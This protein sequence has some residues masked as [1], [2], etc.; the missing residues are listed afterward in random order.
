[1]TSTVK[2]SAVG[3][4]PTINLLSSSNGVDWGSYDLSSDIELTSY[5]RVFLKA[6]ATN[7]RF[8]SS[9]TSYWQFVMTGTIA[10]NGNINSLLNGENP[11]SVQTI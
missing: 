7:K 3:S 5:D 4:A 8:G 11:D 1:V 10:A 9:N 2:L 6:N